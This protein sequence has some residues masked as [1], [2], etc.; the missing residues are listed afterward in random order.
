M[1]AMEAFQRSYSSVKDNENYL[2]LKSI[3]GINS[4]LRLIHERRSAERVQRLPSLKSSN[5]MIDVLNGR[6][7]MIEPKDFLNGNT[8]YT[9]NSLQ[10]HYL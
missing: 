5:I 9:T 7:D 6:D 8:K 2:L 4:S 1:E 3:Q 10:I